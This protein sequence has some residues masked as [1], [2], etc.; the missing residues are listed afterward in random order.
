VAEAQCL[1]Q[2]N[3]VN[4]VPQSYDASRLVFLGETLAT[5]FL[6]FRSIGIACSASSAYQHHCTTLF[7][8]EIHQ[9]Y[10]IKNP[11]IE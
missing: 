3:G 9:L 8:H 10:A 2:S 1:P 11:K 7:F 4:E 5:L 6:G